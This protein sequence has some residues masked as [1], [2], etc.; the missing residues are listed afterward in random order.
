MVYI[1][2][3]EGSK[4]KF[5]SVSER[6]KVRGER[7]KKKVDELCVTVAKCQDSMLI[8]F[9]MVIYQYGGLHVQNQP[10]LFFSF[11]VIC[12]YNLFNP[13]YIKLNL[14]YRLK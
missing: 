10:K 13:L 4:S 12:L 3:M 11:A 6:F 1:I 14:G 7:E 8:G 2:D 5:Q 9:T